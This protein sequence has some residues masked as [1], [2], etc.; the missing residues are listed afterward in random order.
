MDWLLQFA[1]EYPA[2]GYIWFI[3]VTFHDIVQWTVMGALGLTVWGQRKKARDEADKRAKIA[4]AVR[5][6]VDHIHEE[7]HLH[8]KEDIK[9][10]DQLGQDSGLT[11]GT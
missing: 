5:T 6:E 7:L 9:L 3:W 4:A 10:H 8:I 1:N 11:E 2:L